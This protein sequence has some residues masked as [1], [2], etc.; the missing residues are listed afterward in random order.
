M[1]ERDLAIARAAYVRGAGYTDSVERVLTLPFP[2]LDYMRSIIADVD[3]QLAGVSAP[4]AQ[5]TIGQGGGEAQA[6]PPLS[7]RAALIAAVRAAVQ[8][9][10][11]WFADYLNPT[12]DECLALVPAEARRVLLEPE[13]QP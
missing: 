10:F 13:E 7:T 9:P 6:E 11:Y 2:K 12:D 4:C 3:R 1:T 5:P 8:R